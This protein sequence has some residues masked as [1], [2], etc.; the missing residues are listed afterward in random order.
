MA[1]SEQQELEEALSDYLNEH[2]EKAAGVAVIV[3][4]EDEITYLMDGYADIKRQV[5]VDEETIFEWGSVSKVL[6]WISILQLEEAGHLELDK[7][8]ATYLPRDFHSKLSFDSPVTLTHLMNHTAGYDDSYTDLMVLKPA[9]IASLKEVLEAADVRQVFPPGEVVA[10]SN[11]GAGLAAYVVEEVS[12]MDF[13][14]YVQKHIFEPLQMTKTSIDA[15]QNDLPWVKEQR[16][17]VQGYSEDLQL[18]QPN[19]YVI[20]LYP[21]GSVTGVASDLQKLLKALLSEDGAPLF[22]HR[23]TLDALLLPTLYY[24]GTNVPRMANGLVSLP[25]ESGQV[26][27][28]G[29]NTVAFSS[30]F[31]VDRQAGTGVLVMTNMANER[32]FTLGIPEIVF[33]KPHKENPSTLEDS[34][35]WAGIYEP[36]RVPRHGFSKVYGLL[37]RSKSEQAEAHDLTMNGLRYSQTGPGMYLTGDDFSAYAIDVYSEHPVNGNMLSSAQTDML[38]IPI[39]QHLLEW[40][41]IAL[42]ALA[43]LLSI[44]FMLFSLLRKIRIHTILLMQHVLNL[45]A[46]LNAVWIAYRTASITTYTSIHPFLTANLFYVAAS[47]VVSGILIARMRTGRKDK[48][49]AFIGILTVMTAV[50]LTGNILYWEFYF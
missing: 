24:P 32:T 10:Y 43:A 3:V 40:G 4:N 34:S 35:K 41:S 36:A 16:K 28:H 15:E 33:G 17:N 38:R 5:P 39:Y 23:Q 18:I 44:V 8:I 19:H 47:W 25:S 20:P 27:G 13:R 26:F 37:L 2:G 46:V 12:G 21:A 50:V 30:S 31:Y 9:E 45:L 11:Y 6:I 14:L 42:G 1:A 22:R 7:D 29:G 49:E 48:R